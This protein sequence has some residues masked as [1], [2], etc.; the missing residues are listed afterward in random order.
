MS[1][2]QAFRPRI[3]EHFSN[4][5]DPRKCRIQHQLSDIIVIVVLGTLCGEDG[6]EGYAEWAQDKEEYLR[7]FLTLPHGIPCP[8]TFRR[9]MEHLD[10]QEFMHAFSS[11]SEELKERSGGQVCIDGKVLCKALQDGGRPLHLVSAWCQENRMVLGQVQAAAKSNEIPAIEKLLDLLILKDGDIV[12][13][14]AIGCQKTIVSKIHAKGADYVIALKKNQLLLWNEA[15][16]YFEQ[17]LKAAEEAECDFL[18]YETEA[19]G[20]KEIHE[21][22]VSHDLDWLPQLNSWHGLQSLIFV[23]RRW[24]IEG[25]EHEERRFYLSSMQAKA[26]Q[27]GAWIRRH[28]SIENE[29]HWHLD[30][31]FGE[32]E[33]SISGQANQNLRMARNIAL[34]LLKVETSFKSSLAGKMRKCHRSDAYLSKV[35]VSGNF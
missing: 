24:T 30:V 13:I 8:D 33:S 14:D 15:A 2:T 18:A 26:E 5:T 20:R 3:L 17:A 34:K 32:D 11:W 6:W 27:M 19:H 23:R 7:T 9:V 16:N 4:F 10:P 31:T 25:K 21:V 22:W 12:T 28:W 29:Y 35:L 1:S